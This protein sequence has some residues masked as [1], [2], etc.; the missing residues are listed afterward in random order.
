VHPGAHGQLS[1]CSQAC[2]DSFG[3]EPKTDRPRASARAWSTVLPV[4]QGCRSA[5]LQA[6]RRLV[7]KLREPTTSERST[8]TGRTGT[9]SAA[10][11]RRLLPRPG[12]HRRPQRQSQEARATASTSPPPR[13]R[14]VHGRAARP[15]LLAL[16]IFSINLGILLTWEQTTSQASAVIESEETTEL[17]GLAPLPAAATGLPPPTRAPIRPNTPTPHREHPHARRRLLRVFAPEI[18]STPRK[19]LF[20][21][22]RELGRY[23]KAGMARRRQ[24]GPSSKLPT[25]PT[26][27]GVA[28]GAVGAVSS[29]PWGKCARRR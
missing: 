13:K 19:K 2:S 10:L 7:K 26:P 25:Q 1:R 14:L 17:N 6:A 27:R 18:P 29:V 12:R 24:R 3:R 4:Q 28:S 15:L 11:A 21:R 5:S 20:W 22:S 9:T 8:S 23:R 16:M